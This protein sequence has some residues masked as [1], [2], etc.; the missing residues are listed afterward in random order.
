MVPAITKGLASV[1]DESVTA[2]DDSYMVVRIQMHDDAKASRPAVVYL[3]TDNTNMSGFGGL[4][5]TIGGIVIAVVQS[6]LFRVDTPAQLAAAT[7]HVYNL[8]RRARREDPA[9]DLVL[10]PEYCI[11]GLSMNTGPANLCSMDGP[12]VAAFV[13]F[14]PSRPWNVGLTINANG[15]IV[16]YYCKMHPWAPIEPWYPCNRGVSVLTG[17]GGVRMSLITCHDGMFPEMAHEAAYKGAE[18]LLCRAGYTLPVRRGTV[19]ANLTYTA[20]VR[21]RRRDWGVENNLFQLGHRGLI[22]VDGGASGCPY[23]YMRD[24]VA[25]RYAQAEDAEVVRINPNKSASEDK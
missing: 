6:Q 1:R 20:K 12:E 9:T 13:L 24:I 25:G 7:D 21:R 2:S 5:K 11:H 19:A 18:A 10:F 23:T 8:V 15:E 22:A 16:A 14:A 17:P 3:T 4:N